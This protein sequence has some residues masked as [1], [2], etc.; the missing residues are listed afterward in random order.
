[1]TAHGDHPVSLHFWLLAL[2][3]FFLRSRSDARLLFRVLGLVAWQGRFRHGLLLLLQVRSRLH[4]A[5]RNDN[6][7]KHEIYLMR[8]PY[9]KSL[10]KT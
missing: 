2:A 6:Q 9:S 4:E 3:G 5:Q 7:Y 1:M 10:L 8:S